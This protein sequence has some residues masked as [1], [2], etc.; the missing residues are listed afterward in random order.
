[1]TISGWILLVLSWGLIIALNVFCLVK[2]LGKK[3][4]KR[5]GD[6]ASKLS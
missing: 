2:V 1:M 5:E 3:D 6:G 4:E